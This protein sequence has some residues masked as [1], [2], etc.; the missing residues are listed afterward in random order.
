MVR[1][2]V[3]LLN[4]LQ[5]F[6]LMLFKLYKI[7]RREE[8]ES[9]L[10]CFCSAKPFPKAPSPNNSVSGGFS[11]SGLSSSGYDYT[12][13]AEAA[14]MAATAILN[15]STRCWERPETLSTKPREPCTK[16]RGPCS[17]MSLTCS[18][19]EQLCHKDTSACGPE[20]PPTGVHMWLHLR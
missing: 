16:V 12:Q 3:R 20:K 7:K 19:S 5:C 9:I 10:L 11:K 13:D 4:I 18:A 6:C 17:L 8:H 15:L 14:H 2:R 1:L